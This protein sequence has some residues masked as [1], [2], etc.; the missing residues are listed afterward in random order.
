[1]SES[2]AV[3]GAGTMGHGIA[4]VS[5]MAGYD[6][7]LFDVMPD[8]LEAARSKIE[9]NL[10]TGIQRGK[11]EPDDMKRALDALRTTDDLTQAANAATVVIEAVPEKLEL[12][13][14]LLCACAEV[15]GAEALLATNT[16]S[17][18]ITR[19]AEMVPEPD[20]VVGMHFFNPV[21]IMA[22]VEI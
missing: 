16:S 11:I 6:T 12:K 10:A 7:W 4:Q 19:I 5:A 8:A 3:L 22:L 18:S 2:I 15:A 17:L 14:S 21:H 13:Q 9:S 20:R 1:M